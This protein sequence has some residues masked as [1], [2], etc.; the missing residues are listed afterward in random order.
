[1]P[2]FRHLRYFAA[3]A[4]ELHFGHAAKRLGIA[5][6][7]LSRQIQALEDE[8]GISLFDRTQR[9]VELTPA[10]RVLLEHTHRVFGAVELA[11]HE[12]KRASVGES[13]RIAIG[14]LSSLAYSGLIDLLR[15]FRERFAGVEVTLREMPPSAQI[16]A[17]KS[18]DIDV[19]F[20]R[21]PLDDPSLVAERVRREPLVIALPTDHALSA[22]ERIPLSAL[23]K[24]PFVIFPRSRGPGFFDEIMALCRNAGFVP[25]IVQEAPQLDL[26]S[27]VAAGFGVSILPGSMRTVKRPGVVFR[28]IVGS[29]KTD[30][31]VAWRAGNVSPTLH[32]FLELVR[33][34]GVE[35]K[36][37]SGNVA[38]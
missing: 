35:R 9:R 13:G 14:Y 11:V 5:Q 15:E 18:S 34:V 6:P 22:R 7:P 28:A 26:V 25:R 20:V 36:R 30:V 12:A 16:D 23:A 19:G 17:L 4:E 33:I 37:G 3:V 1:M 2:E 10:G 38:R 31:L 32:K 8:L 24:E 29:P 27:L 21:A